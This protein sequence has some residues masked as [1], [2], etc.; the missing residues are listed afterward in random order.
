ML[1]ARFFTTLLFATSAS[2]AAAQP[3]GCEPFAVQPDFTRVWQACQELVAVLP[4]QQL[5][6]RLDC[7]VLQGE[8]VTR[9]MA[10]RHATE[11]LMQ[12][13][14]YAAAY[15]HYR[16]KAAVLAAWV[17]TLPLRMALASYHA[18][19]G[20]LPATL[21]GLGQPQAAWQHASAV[22][23]LPN[24]EIVV[25]L[26]AT[27]VAGGELRLLPQQDDV[28]LLTYRCQGRAVAAALLPPACRTP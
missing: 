8:A 20:H 16:N 13:P 25:S 14:A 17:E 6:P 7:A 3:S 27:V 23:L 21:A 12:Q 4:Q 10:F 11:T 24:G 18:E 26:P 5:P 9:C 1:F 15:A 19:H 28:G 22:A 2:V